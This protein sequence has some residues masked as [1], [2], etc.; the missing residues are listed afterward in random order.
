MSRDPRAASAAA[1][2]L[3]SPFRLNLEQQGKRAKEL[4]KSLRA[5]DDEALSRFR[6]H[7]PRSADAPERLSEAQLVVARELGLPSWPKL[8][9]HI[10]AMERSWRGIV[11]G[12]AAPDRGMTT[13]HLRCGHDIEASLRDAGFI[14]DFLE[15][16]D[17]LCQGPVLD[18]ADWLA[19]RAAFLAE[20][21]GAGVDR[22]EAQIAEELAVAE[23]RLQAA[24][25]RYERVVLWLEHDPYDQLILARCLAQF[26]ETPPPRLEL[27]S[28]ERYPGA[29][30]FLGLGQLPPEA[31][32]L[33]WEE[34]AP[35]AEA[36]LLAGRE[37]WSMLRAPDPRPLA[38][39]ARAGAPA[40]PQLARAVRRHCQEFPGTEDGLSLTERLILEL[41][42][43][44]PHKAVD[45][46]SRLLME[47]EPLPWLTDLMIHS[48]VE[49][50][51]RV[52]EPV[53]T[54]AFDSDD[55]SWPKERLTI[56]PLGR[57]I[58][59]GETDWMSLRPPPRWLGG[60]SISGDAPCW[61]W[62]EAR[63][64]FAFSQA[65]RRAER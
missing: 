16:S 49:D 12:E 6:R 18:R 1:V 10:A 8:K 29:T 15:Y 14:G 47:R 33:L 57:A 60:V 23:A 51:K 59:A 42:A 28:L 17:P 52:A 21:Y 22:S 25:S 11:R 20:S 19:E 32:R 44:R 3:A 2:R 61:R 65:A 34:R 13:L 37:V 41:L 26:A 30:R 48:I 31:L 24:A 27:I 39:V 43:E 45:A 40:L 46:Y 4:L 54:G 56:T 62:D 9:A 53:F 5:G 55:R 64:E 50:M 35:V 38:G 7:H 58:L 63:S 36:A